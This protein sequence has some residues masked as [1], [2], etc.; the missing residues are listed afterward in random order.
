MY[1]PSVRRAILRA[2]V[3]RR[4]HTLCC[5]NLGTGLRLQARYLSTEPEASHAKPPHESSSAPASLTTA[6]GEGHAHDLASDP[7]NSASSATPSSLGNVIQN[8]NERLIQILEGIADSSSGLDSSAQAA[9]SQRDG[10]MQETADVP[11]PVPDVKPSRRI[12][13]RVQGAKDLPTFLAAIYEVE[14]RFG[15]IRDYWIATV[16]PR[17]ISLVYPL[18]LMGMCLGY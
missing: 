10:N 12:V 6:P 5:N 1:S 2:R 14:R 3:A 8:S 17:G 15:R 7:S 18:C 4:T 11:K 16:R 13:L 9:G